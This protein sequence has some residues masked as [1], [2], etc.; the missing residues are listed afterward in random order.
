MDLLPVLFFVVVVAFMVALVLWVV[1]HPEEEPVD[2]RGV[3]Y[4]L[5]M[6]LPPW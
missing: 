3:K 4:W 1:R 2:E 5:K 6:L